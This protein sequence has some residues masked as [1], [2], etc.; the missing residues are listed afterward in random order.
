MQQARKVAAATSAARLASRPKQKQ[1][2]REMQVL[3]HTVA[4][5]DTRRQNAQTCP[6]TGNAREKQAYAS[7]AQV[8]GEA[9]KNGSSSK[10]SC[11]EIDH[12]AKNFIADLYPHNT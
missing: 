12:D 3:L 4:V 2:N 8:E 1:E 9:E 10:H 11:E 5:D 6:N 7:E